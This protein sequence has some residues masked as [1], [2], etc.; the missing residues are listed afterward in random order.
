MFLAKIENILLFLIILFLPT[1]LGLHLWPQ[2]SYIYS[3]KVDY[4]S[5]TLYFWDILV[6]GLLLVWVVKKPHINTTALNLF[7]FF[8]F[9]QALSL[10]GSSNIGVGLL[11]LEQYVLAGFFGVF[12]A[13]YD[14]KSLS[15]KVYLPLSLGILGESFIAILQFIKGGTLGLW[16]L[17]ERSFS[18][19]TPGI[20]KFDFYGHEFL[21]PYATFPHPN[22][23]AGFMLISIIILIHL[24]VIARRESSI[25][26]AI[27]QTGK[28]TSPLR[29]LAMTILKVS[30]FLAALTIFL[31][32][33]RT[34]ILAGFIAAFFLAKEKGRIILIITTIVLFPVLF[35]RFVSV[36]NFDTLTLLRREEL[37][38]S[39]WQLFL[40]SPL[41]GIGLNNFIPVMANQLVTG[42]SRFLQ[43]VHNIFLLVLSETGLIGL[44][45]LIVLIGYPVFKLYYYRLGLTALL[46]W[47]LIIFLGMFDHYFLT[48]PQG[49]RMLF[50]VWG[51]SFSLLKAKEEANINN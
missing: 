12:L 37:M 8:L 22:V 28:I 29:G 14:F 2:F 50:L 6:A 13:T 45:G 33:S 15:G 25:G 21:R 36:L 10:L 35:T 1:Q 47:A 41:Y 11:R 44:I 26:V 19:S 40:K 46:P 3:L 24:S 51:L 23:L 30:G 17:G 4:L 32:M 38:G 20:A 42:P 9:T 31:S 18:I 34:A 39:A 43:P 27:Y 48:L 5:P 49:Y 7:L 16:I